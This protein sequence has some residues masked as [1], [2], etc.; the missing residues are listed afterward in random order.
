MMTKSL[1]S[2]FFRWRPLGLLTCVLF[3]CLRS[4]A[5]PMRV[6]VSIGPQLE[7]VKFIGGDLVVVEAL[8]P[9]GV[10]PETYVPPPRSIAALAKASFL[11]TIGVPFENALLPKVRGA[12]PKLAIIDGRAGMELMPMEEGLH[13][14][15]HGHG[16]GHKH[17]DF[18]PHVWLL[19]GNMK[20]HARTV[21]RTLSERLPA[22]RAEIAKRAEAYI[23][24]LEK[25]DEEF[26]RQLAPLKGRTAMVFHPAFGYF[27]K[28][29]GLRQLAV[30][31]DGREPTGRYL[32]EL[33]RVAK[34]SRVSCIFV[35]PQFNGKTV[36]V[37]AREI[38]GAV[39]EVDPLPME[40]SSGMRQ[41][42]RQFL[43]IGNFP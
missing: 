27:L 22:H 6:F 1:P 2:R 11:L 28:H 39:V 14:H 43:S 35:Q 41:L 40:Y 37:V 21:A 15:D 38:G 12:F 16:H 24:S 13:D 29:Y 34:E 17:G 25:L 19:L 8:V 18:D 9:P 5:E 3:S 42:C 26:R 20:V 31:M 10:S 36:Q 7:S 23:A 30:E 4:V 32:G 33:L